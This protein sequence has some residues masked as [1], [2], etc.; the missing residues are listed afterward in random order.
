[1]APDSRESLATTDKFKFIQVVSI[2]YLSLPIRP[3]HPPFAF[4][5]FGSTIPLLCLKNSRLF[6][7][8]KRGQWRITDHEYFQTPFLFP[9]SPSLSLPPPAS[10][11]G[12]LLLRK[13]NYIYAHNAI[14]KEAHKDGAHKTIFFFFLLSFFLSL[15]FLFFFLIY[16]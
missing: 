16:F 13:K 14:K 8:Y 11:L 9:F 10:H 2:R 15:F 1:M 6:T 5:Q 12:L 3:F 7:G 4:D